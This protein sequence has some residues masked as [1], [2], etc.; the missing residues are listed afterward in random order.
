MKEILN[1]KEVWNI[2]RN[3]RVDRVKSLWDDDG[4][5]ESVSVME[6]CDDLNEV[7]R[8]LEGFNLRGEWRL[9]GFDKEGNELFERVVDFDDS[10]FY[11]E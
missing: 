1:I 5:F 9:E 6:C 4:V 2:L 11:G 10:V 7:Y 8:D 3:S